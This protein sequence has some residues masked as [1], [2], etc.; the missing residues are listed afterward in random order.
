MVAIAETEDGE[1]VILPLCEKCVHGAFSPESWTK[2]F[3]TYPKTPGRGPWEES[4]DPVFD[5]EFQFTEYG[6]GAKR[7]PHKRGPI[8]RLRL[9]VA[10]LLES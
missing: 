6:L 10:E 1:Q 4:S 7:Y 3:G 9:P 2:L 8:L 5:G